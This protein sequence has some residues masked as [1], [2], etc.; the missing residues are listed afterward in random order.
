MAGH[1]LAR[2]LCL[3]RFELST[4]KSVVWHSIQLSYRH[5]I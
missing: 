2:L 1:T 4:S 3:E 5:V